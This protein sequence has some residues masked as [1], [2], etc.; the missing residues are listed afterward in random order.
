[1]RDLFTQRRE[2]GECRD[3]LAKQASPNQGGSKLPHSKKCAGLLVATIRNA[4]GNVT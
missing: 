2:S 3:R 4:Y 1:M